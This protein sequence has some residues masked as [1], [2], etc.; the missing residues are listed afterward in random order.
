MPVQAGKSNDELKKILDLLG[1]GDTNIDPQ[2]EVIRE[3]SRDSMTWEERL[4]TTEAKLQMLSNRF[5]F[6]WQGIA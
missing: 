2:G 3:A 5:P 4:R 1:T 6:V